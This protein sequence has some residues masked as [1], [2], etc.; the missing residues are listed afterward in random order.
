MADASANPEE[1][2]ESGT[3]RFGCFSVSHFHIVCRSLYGNSSRARLPRTNIEFERIL[4]GACI[5]FLVCRQTG[6]WQQERV[7]FKR[8][9]QRVHTF[10]T[11]SL[12]DVLLHERPNIMK[13]QILL[14]IFLLISKHDSLQKQAYQI[15]PRPLYYHCLVPPFKPG[16]FNWAISMI[17]QKEV[18]L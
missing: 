9:I 16:H 7:N 1:K 5:I 14:E 18:P 10:V 2:R 15:T 11:N 3:S 12:R 4:M 8:R 17:L 13:N 6:C